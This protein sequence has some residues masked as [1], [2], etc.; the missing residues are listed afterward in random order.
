MGCDYMVH[1]KSEDVVMIRKIY[2]AAES[3]KA[4]LELERLK[5]VTNDY[6]KIKEMIEDDAKNESRHNSDS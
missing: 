1:K 6:V 3:R 4:K 2:G 5:F